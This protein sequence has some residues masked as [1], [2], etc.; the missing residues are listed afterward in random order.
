M[1]DL[2][3]YRQLIGRWPMIWDNT[4]YARGLK[5]QSYGGYPTYYPG[6]VKLCNLFEPL[7]VYRPA[8]FQ[9]YS[10]G[11]HMYTNGAAASEV[12]RIKYATVA[13]Y[14]W[15]TAA[16]DPERSL[17]KVLCRLYG[18]ACAEALLRFNNAYYAVFEACLGME[19]AGAQ[20]GYRKTVNRYL[21]EMDDQ[22]ARISAA[23]TES[24]PLIKELQNYRT[25]QQTW[26]EKLSRRSES[27]P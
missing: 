2:H 16:Y 5:T 26:F 14:E 24:N 23:L 15:N 13:D 18:P 8:G 21:R 6:K 17:W 3:R 11:G 7:D 12:Y 10:D 22:I 1:A 20:A 9:N 25:A 19:A 4:L 27:T